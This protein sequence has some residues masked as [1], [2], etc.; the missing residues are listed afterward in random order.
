MNVNEFYDYI[1][2]QMTPEQAL[3][4]LLE[5]HVLTYEK[6][7]FKR[8]K[9]IHPLILILMATMDLGWNFII[10]NNNDLDD[11]VTGMIIG[12][13]EYIESTFNKIEKNE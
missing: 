7:K 12:T 13:K 11:E 9:E 5:G 2:K 4:K 3:K 1:T 10:E 6:L 8:G